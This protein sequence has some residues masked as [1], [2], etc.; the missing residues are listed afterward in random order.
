MAM[1]SEQQEQFQIHYQAG[2]LA[3]EKGQY[4]LSVELLE[5]ASKLVPPATRLGGEAQFWLVSAYQATGQ[6]QE[7]I[8]LCRQLSRHPHPEIRKQGIRLLY[9]LEAP[10]LKRPQ[11]WMS[12]IPDLS[13]ST[14]IGTRY[15]QASG[16]P[17]KAS[18]PPQPAIQQV[19]LTQIN[20]KDNRFVWVALLLLLLSL[21]GLAWWG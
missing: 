3:F 18:N 6:T 15:L 13:Q 20:T 17:S 4:R 1:A 12:Q 21:G 19:D 10:R 11:E 7:A 9:I 2:L 14:E 5:A 8:A 16:S